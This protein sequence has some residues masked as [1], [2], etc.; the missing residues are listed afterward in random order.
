MTQQEWLKT[1]F[2]GEGIYAPPA[3]HMEDDAQLLLLSSLVL[4]R[5]KQ[6]ATY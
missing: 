5:W 1:D 6:L 2:N 3:L 4:E